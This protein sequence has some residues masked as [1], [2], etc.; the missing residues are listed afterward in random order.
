MDLLCCGY[1]LLLSKLF[2]SWKFI[3]NFRQALWHQSLTMSLTSMFVITISSWYLTRLSLWRGSYFPVELHIVWYKLIQITNNWKTCKV[4]K[5]P[6]FNQLLCNVLCF[7]LKCQYLGNSPLIRQSILWKVYV[8]ILSK[9]H[10]S[11]IQKVIK[12]KHVQI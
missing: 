4:Y 10:Y 12:C 3:Q 11:H 5:N 7:Q 8:G 1:G 9:L 2:L 6:V